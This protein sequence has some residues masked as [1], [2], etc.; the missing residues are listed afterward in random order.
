[1]QHQSNPSYSHAE[2]AAIAKKLYGLEG[3]LK[4][5]VSYDDQN[6]KL[7]VDDK[8]YV[9]KI[10]NKIADVEDIEF[11]LA[12]MEHLHEKLPD[13]GL[14]EV[15]H[16]LEGGTITMYEGHAVRLLT[17]V[18]GEVYAY[19]KRSPELHASFGRY[20]GAFNR[21]MEGFSHPG[22]DRGNFIWGLDNVILC[23]PF[24]HN[25]I[26]EEN[27]A[28]VERYFERYESHVL[29]KLK[30][31]RKAIIHQ[32]ANDHN[33]LVNKAG[34]VC[35]LIDFGDISCGSLINELAIMLGYSLQ[36]T[37]DVLGANKAI[38]SEYV[39]VYPL[40]REE[41][42]VVMDLAAMRAVQSVT[43]SSRDSKDSPENEYLIVSQ[44][45]GFD[46]LEKFEK[47][48][49]DF[50]SQFALFSAFGDDYAHET[51]SAIGAVAKD[52]IA[53][54]FPFDLKTEKHIT[55][56][57]KEGAK[58]NELIADQVAYGVWLNDRI[59]TEG[60][61]YAIGLYGEDRDCYTTANFVDTASGE[62]RSVHLG[63]DLFVP[64]ETPL[65]APLAGKVF[66]VH[67]NA[68]AL[69]YGPTIILEHTLPDSGTV[70]YTL[71]GHLAR[72]SLSMVRVGEI[73]EAG[74]QI[75][76]IGDITV[77]GGWAPHLHFQIMTTML[78]NSHD[79]PG[80]C[81]ASR[82]DVWKTICLD[83]DLLLRM[84]GEDT[85]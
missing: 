75:G 71:Y 16:N 30:G 79:F 35:G 18:P 14:P 19:A 53:N 24:V 12:C 21:A 82:W 29:P 48:G 59:E 6:A 43:L 42:E 20:M 39:K 45:P 33:V 27:R 7:T 41:V 73:V 1:M 17:Y 68:G 51:V 22:A 44:A 84:N 23:K 72:K 69:D 74:Q 31:M 70:F 58:G 62:P 60:A 61:K 50:L 77:N 38:I 32:D 13:S 67:D 9:L 78:G 15:I 3:T 63:L 55:V 52:N 49:M 83:P 26:K 5:L 54:L 25:I 40:E 37:E 76:L 56:S 47:L 4:S 64:A 65:H 85:T 28:R 57:M 2:M 34:E 80:A 46:L 11:Q 8:S 66:S 36:K 81:E 10:A